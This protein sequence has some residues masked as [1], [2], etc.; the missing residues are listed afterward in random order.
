[1]NG[2]GSV[3]GM[4]DLSLIKVACFV[5]KV[6][7]IFKIKSSRSKL[8]STNRPD[9]LILPLQYGFLAIITTRNNNE[10]YHGKLYVNIFDILL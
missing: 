4:V 8:V 3:V 2:E 1:M 5:T 9:V 6:N 7:N 10:Y